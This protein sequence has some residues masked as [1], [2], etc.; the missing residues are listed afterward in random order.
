MKIVWTRHARKRITEI[1]D[2]IAADSPD[3]AADFCD[4]LINSADQ[5]TD[6]PLSGPLVPEDPAYRQLVVEKYRIIYRLG[7]AEIYIMTIVAPGML[8]DQA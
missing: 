2:Y 7:G 5:L 6:H 8:Y 1:Y 3:R 4:T